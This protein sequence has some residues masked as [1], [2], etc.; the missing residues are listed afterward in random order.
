MQSVTGTG[1]RR[2]E[3][4]GR[5]QAA[6]ERAVRDVG[7]VVGGTVRKDAGGSVGFPVD[8][9]V[10]VL[11][12]DRPAATREPFLDGE[13]GRQLV[14][15]EVRDGEVA[16]Q[17]LAYDVLDRLEAL[18]DRHARVEAVEV[19]HVHVVELQPSQRGVQGIEDV[20][21][22]KPTVVGRRAIHA[23]VQLGGEDDVAALVGVGPEPP[24]DQAFGVARAGVVAVGRVPERHA[25]LDR[26]VEDRECRAFVDAGVV[27]GV[28]VAELPGAEADRR[29]AQTGGSDQADAMMPD[30]RR[31][32]E[33]AFRGTLTTP[34]T[35]RPVSSPLRCLRR[36]PECTGLGRPG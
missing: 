11:H 30:H 31:A 25:Q 24:A 8:R 12:R 36:V 23:A 14:T 27:A 18:L 5:Q 15:A 29:C 32:T 28:G 7:H 20:A 22:G 26:P 34:G 9:V 13:V 21:A 10:P 17:T 35:L 16:D 4:A 2:V 3:V 33:G 1:A 19:Q 6:G